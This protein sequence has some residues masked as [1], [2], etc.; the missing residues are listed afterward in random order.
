ML[1]E[2][3]NIYNLEPPHTNSHHKNVTAYQKSFFFFGTPLVSTNA[4]A[5]PNC[6]IIECDGPSRDFMCNR[7]NATKNH[8]NI[9]SS[10]KIKAPKNE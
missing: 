6:Q 2:A 1:I 5:L 9:N 7:T 8:Q 10:Q 3:T 4:Q